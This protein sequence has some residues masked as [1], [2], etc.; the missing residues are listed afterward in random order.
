MS[1]WTPLFQNRARS[2]TIRTGT[3]VDG[4][5]TGQRKALKGIMIYTGHDFAIQAIAP[6]REVVSIGYNP[7][8]IHPDTVRKL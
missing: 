6:A 5:I 4:I 2:I 8:Q 7:G 3:P 1:E